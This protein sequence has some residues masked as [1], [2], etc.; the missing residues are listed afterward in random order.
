MADPLKFLLD[1]FSFNASSISRWC[2]GERSFILELTNGNIG[3]CSHFNNE[4]QHFKEFP[5]K[6][7][8]LNNSHRVL[9]NAYFNASFNHKTE[10]GE[11]DIF[12][13]IDFSQ[14]KN[15][16]LIG[17]FPSLVRKFRNIGIDLS[18]F[19]PLSDDPEII[20]ES[21]KEEYLANAD[22]LIF[23]A[24]TVYNQTFN[25]LLNPTRSDC[26]KFLLGPSAIQCRQLLDYYNLDYI[27]GSK[28]KQSDDEL[29][30]IIENGG[31]TRDFT[32]RIR[33]VYICKSNRN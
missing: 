6:I 25:S 28:F 27:F 30:R 29:F 14:F 13:V 12:D 4:N 3:V 22:A 5:A 10:D 32:D 16:V 21:K 31:G 9:L 23:T 24:T 15:I 2:F 7:D 17:F 8:L 18:I 33:K 1:K 19:D 11:G 20:P 26:K